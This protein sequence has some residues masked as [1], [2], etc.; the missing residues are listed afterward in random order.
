MSQVQCLPVGAGKN[1]SK[2]KKILEEAQNGQNR[3]L[4]LV[5]KNL[6]SFD[7]LPNI[8]K[9]ARKVLEMSKY[10]IKLIHW[11]PYVYKFLKIR[12]IYWIFLFMLQF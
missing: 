9:W 7:E 12:K 2:V 10:G 3:E 1:M 8:C 6:H 5:E 11:R 4:D